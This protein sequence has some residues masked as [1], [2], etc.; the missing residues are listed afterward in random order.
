VVVIEAGSRALLALRAY[1]LRSRS[2]ESQSGTI[3]ASGREIVVETDGRTGFNVDGELVS[4]ACFRFTV[5]PR[6]VEVVVGLRREL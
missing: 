4:G 6:A 3:S 2:L 5:Q 1:G